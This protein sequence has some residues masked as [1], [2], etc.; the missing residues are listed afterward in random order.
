MQ[1]IVIQAVGNREDVVKVPAVKRLRQPGFNPFVELC[2]LTLRA[3][4]VLA[5]VVRNVDLPAFITLFNVTAERSRPAV[6]KRIQY[7]LVI[8]QNIVPG[9]EASAVSPDNI[10]DFKLRLHAKSRKAYP[11]D[12]LP[13]WA[14]PVLCEDT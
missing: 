11:A 3:V 10:R 5:A 4:T 14:I 13:I 6:L 7:P 12:F 1:A 2:A 9:I 8:V